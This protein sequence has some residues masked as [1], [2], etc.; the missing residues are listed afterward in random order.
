MQ[1][2]SYP[3]KIKGRFKVTSYKLGQ[4]SFSTMQSFFDN[5]LSRMLGKYDLLPNG[6]YWKDD[7]GYDSPK[8]YCRKQDEK[9]S[10]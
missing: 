8:C 4:D 3:H 7:S 6:N 9:K 10:P 5:D 2:N 1:C